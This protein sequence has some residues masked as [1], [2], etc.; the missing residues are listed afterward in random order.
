MVTTFFLG[1]VALMTAVIV[2][3]SARYQPRER[4][5]PV[6]AE[7]LPALAHAILKIQI[8]ITLQTAFVFAQETHRF[9]RFHAI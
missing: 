4:E 5:A 8:G 2:L 6:R 7:P 1:F 3:M 9:T